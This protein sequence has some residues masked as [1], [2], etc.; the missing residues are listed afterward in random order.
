MK[1]SVSM[2]EKSEIRQIQGQLFLGHSQGAWC[3]T[4]FACWGLFI[5]LFMCEPL[6]V[7]GS[8]TYL[9]VRARGGRVCTGARSGGTAF[10]RGFPCAKNAVG[11]ALAGFRMC[12]LCARVHVRVCFRILTS[13]RASGR[14]LAVALCLH[15]LYSIIYH[16]RQAVKSSADLIGQ[17]QE[18]Q[19]SWVSS[20]A[21]VEKIERFVAQ[22]ETEFCECARYP[23]RTP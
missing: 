9:C 2:V 14:E 23:S 8:N 1:S 4:M 7:E 19:T 12:C 15:L 16:I 6:C 13:T 17:M 20:P 5:L 18:W 3:L 10:P 21:E 11:N 22:H